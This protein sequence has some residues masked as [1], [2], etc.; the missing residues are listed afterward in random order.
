[1]AALSTTH[2]VTGR[3]LVSSIYSWDIY[4]L[5]SRG[6][7]TIAVWYNNSLEYIG[8]FTVH[9]G[10]SPSAT[11]GWVAESHN[12]W[13]APEP[14]RNTTIARQHWYKYQTEDQS[15][16]GKLLSEDLC[17]QITKLCQVE[18]WK[19]QHFNE[20]FRQIKERYNKALWRISFEKM[21]SN[22]GCVGKEWDPPKK[23]Q[24]PNW[25]LSVAPKKEIFHSHWPVSCRFDFLGTL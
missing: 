11:L 16:L 10:N 24:N 4:E 23:R 15:H 7:G 9:L 20:H 3:R 12:F 6:Q 8:I 17:A 19:D 5:Y 1:M 2:D 18:L 13:A 14:H 22:L 25:G 21:L